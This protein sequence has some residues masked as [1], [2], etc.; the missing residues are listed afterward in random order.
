MPAFAHLQEA[1]INALY[2]YLTQLA[3]APDAPP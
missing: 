1:D 2:A 3:G